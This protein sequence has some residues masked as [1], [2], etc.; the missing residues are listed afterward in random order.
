MWRELTWTSRGMRC[1]FLPRSSKHGI[2]QALPLSVPYLARRYFTYPFASLHHS[3]LILRLPSLMSFCS[4]PIPLPHGTHAKQPPLMATHVRSIVKFR[5]VVPYSCLSCSLDVVWSLAW[6]V[7]SVPPPA[8]SWPSDLSWSPT[9]FLSA[10][11]ARTMASSSNSASPP[12]PP[13]SMELEIRRLERT[14]NAHRGLLLRLDGEGGRRFEMVEE[15]L[16]Q[17]RE[18]VVEALTHTKRQTN[19]KIVEL[20]AQIEKLELQAADSSRRTSAGAKT[21]PSASSITPDPKV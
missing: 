3:S 15:D 20:E 11:L 8:R 7:C 14:L 1:M 13:P 19:N 4:K 6:L 18:E 16:I 10:S 12:N 2:P 5:K 21:S 17:L 9:W